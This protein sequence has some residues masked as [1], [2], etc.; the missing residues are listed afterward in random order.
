[1]EGKSS[2]QSL[3]HEVLLSHHLQHCKVHPGLWPFF[4]VFAGPLWEA[5][6]LEHQG[7]D[8]E[9]EDLCCCQLEELIPGERC[10]HHWVLLV[11][12]Q[13]EHAPLQELLQDSSLN[14]LVDVPQVQD[15]SC[16][17]R[18]QDSLLKVPDSKPVEQVLLAL[19]Q[20]EE[21]QVCVWP[22]DNDGRKW[23]LLK[24]S[25]HCWEVSLKSCRPPCA[26]LVVAM[27]FS[28]VQVTPSDKYAAK[29][30]RS[31]PEGLMAW[32][33]VLQAM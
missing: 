13:E 32:S 5:K 3:G 30:L 1:M 25:L 17:G 15:S 20:L 28:L 33:Q 12:V 22:G 14:A 23:L 18:A 24:R 9:I 26:G 7:T 31:R 6:P 10:S 21:L 19:Q 16:G 2:L 8:I 11:V 4:K 29:A 27:S